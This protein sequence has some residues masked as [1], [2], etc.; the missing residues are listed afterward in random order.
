[1]GIMQ[2]GGAVC[3]V[4][5][6]SGCSVRCDMPPS[7][8][9][10]LGPNEWFNL[11]VLRHPTHLPSQVPA[12]VA[13]HLLD[14]RHSGSRGTTQ[15]QAQ[16]A[17][18]PRSQPPSQTQSQSQSQSQQPL[19][20]DALMAEAAP[21]SPSA[22]QAD[23]EHVQARVAQR[24]GGAPRSP[25]FSRTTAADHVPVPDGRPTEKVVAEGLKGC[26]RD[27][28]FDAQEEELESFLLGIELREHEPAARPGSAASTSSV[29][30]LNSPNSLSGRVV[31][32]SR[33]GAPPT[34]ATST[35]QL[36]SRRPNCISTSKHQVARQAS[37]G[38]FAPRVPTSSQFEVLAVSSRTGLTPSSPKPPRV[39]SSGCLSMSRRS[40]GF[41]QDAVT[42]FLPDAAVRLL[43]TS[44][45]F[46]NVG[47]ASTAAA[48]SA[49]GN[50]PLSPSSCARSV[51]S[52]SGGVPYKQ[53]HENVTVL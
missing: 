3:L 38:C 52:G 48:A 25:R 22:R 24:A 53:S 26:G 5:S 47:G 37:F 11:N 9:R 27:G 29:P 43:R 21:A 46:R 40:T 8:K 13:H 36:L 28:G 16:A 42:Q 18:P 33:G 51:A 14:V 41:V 10:K 4:Y 50:A 15:S 44:V 1:M 30:Q 7:A 20:L 2:A 35:G 31:R 6:D 34:R 17:L 12:H 39:S 19:D 49:C 45:S 32:C 23:P